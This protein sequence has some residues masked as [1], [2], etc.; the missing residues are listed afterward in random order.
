[1]FRLILVASFVSG[2]ILLGTPTPALAGPPRDFILAAHPRH[3]TN[4]KLDSRLSEVW[5][6]G[7]S[8]GLR[9]AIDLAERT[10]IVALGESVEAYVVPSKTATAAEAAVIRNS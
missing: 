10:G 2:V 9:G 5:A 7:R 3:A 6:A 4:P 1:M 8:S